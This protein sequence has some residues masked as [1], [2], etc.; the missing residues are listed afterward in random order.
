MSQFDQ[1]IREFQQKR[2]EKEIYSSRVRQE[3]REQLQEL[4]DLADIEMR[5]RRA[6]PRRYI[7]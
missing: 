5:Q 1:V 3:R 7:Y 2:V 6:R 4:A